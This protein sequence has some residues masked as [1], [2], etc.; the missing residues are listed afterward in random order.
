MNTIKNNVHLI[1]NIG[2]DVIL[3]QF[4]S[5]NQKAS[6]RLATNDFYKNK[7]GEKVQ[8]TQW[9][10]LIAWGKKAEFMSKLLRKGNEIAIQGKLTHRSYEDKEGITRYTSEIVVNEFMKITKEDLP[11]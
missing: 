11:F 5:G 10:N 1:G 3:T 9:H 4:D 7:D 6:L 8:E 2:Q